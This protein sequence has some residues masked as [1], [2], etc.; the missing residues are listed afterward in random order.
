MK[1]ARRI[2]ETTKITQRLTREG[3][4]IVYF[5]A[6][7]FLLIALVTY[8]PSDPGFTTTGSGDEIGNAVGSYG[9]WLADFLLHLFGYLS[10]LFPLLLAYQVYRSFRGTELEKGFS[11]LLFLGWSMR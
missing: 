5:L 6:G 8:S 10:F 3:T 11:W 7:L 9:A 4:L 1:T 2:P